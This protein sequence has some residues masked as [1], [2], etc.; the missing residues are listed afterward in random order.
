MCFTQ[1]CLNS[2]F[3]CK[4]HGLTDRQIQRD[5]KQATDRVFTGSKRV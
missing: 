2:G 1:Y 4:K 3:L 5:Y